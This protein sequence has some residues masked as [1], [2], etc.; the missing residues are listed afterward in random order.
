MTYFR[1]HGIAAGLATILLI[2]GGCGKSPAGMTN[3][4][5][6]QESVRS[7]LQLQ[8]NDNSKEIYRLL[9]S[10]LWKQHGLPLSE[11][12]Q[13]NMSDVI[14]K[15]ARKEKLTASDVQN[16]MADSQRRVEAEKKR[17]ADDEAKGIVHLEPSES[18][19]TALVL[20]LKERPQ[21]GEYE[22][23]SLIVKAMKESWPEGYNALN[24]RARPTLVKPDD[25]PACPV[26]G[27]RYEHFLKISND[28]WS[29]PVFK[30]L[31][32]M[33][34][35]SLPDEAMLGVLHLTTVPDT[36]L[37]RD[38]YYEDTYDNI[39]K[40]YGPRLYPALIECMANPMVCGLK[41]S[42]TSYM[43]RHAADWPL[44]I[45]KQLLQAAYKSGWNSAARMLNMKA[46]SAEIAASFEDSPYGKPE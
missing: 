27:K 40:E 15:N 2:S 29:D 14:K 13:R 28:Y 32:K 12:D 41:D 30:E 1:M 6:T 18:L 16:L 38:G 36:G 33:P 10:A 25:C 35:N 8:N 46:E 17:K 19:E 9:E 42:D 37:R 39:M 4:L 26:I 3:K 20:L 5:S 24:F 45:K 34:A 21:L 31:N 7:I 43:L 23:K 44:N 11:N 22:A